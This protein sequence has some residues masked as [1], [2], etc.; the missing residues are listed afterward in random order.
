MG[1]KLDMDALLE[2]WKREVPAVVVAAFNR[3]GWTCWNTQ[4]HK[5]DTFFI[6]IIE[7][8]LTL[9]FLAVNLVLT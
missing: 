2:V 1:W 3:R 4:R 5:D 9:S 7:A 6:M 8:K